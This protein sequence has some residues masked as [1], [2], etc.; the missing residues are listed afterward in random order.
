M[1]SVPL[2]LTLSSPAR[3]HQSMQNS[4][5]S[6]RISSKSRVLRAKVAEVWEGV[7][8]SSPPCLGNQSREGQRRSTLSTQ[9][10][11]RKRSLTILKMRPNKQHQKRH[12]LSSL[13][14]KYQ[15]ILN[16]QL[17]ALWLNS[18]RVF[19]YSLATS[20]TRQRGKKYFSLLWRSQKN[21]MAKTRKIHSLGPLH[22]PIKS[23]ARLTCQA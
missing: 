17:E 10:K 3:G 4:R 8:P 16:R 21:K 6:L 11:T 12:L 14:L 15:I 13:H 22:W 5:P 20:K 2:T 7:V 18:N 1:V 23:V 19:P 9:Q